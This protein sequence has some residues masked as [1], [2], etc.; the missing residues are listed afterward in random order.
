M[1]DFS[2]IAEFFSGTIPPRVMRFARAVGKGIN[3]LSMIEEGD[4]ILLGIS[5]GK[6]SLAMALALALRRK[7]VPVHYHLEAVMIQWREHQFS[8][9]ERDALAK[10][11]SALGVP[12]SIITA[13]MR[14]D[15][16]RGKFNCY[17][18]S[19]NRKRILFDEIARRGFNKVAFGHHLDDIVETTLMNVCFRGNFSTMMPVQEF[20]GGKAHVVRPMS[21]VPERT[22]ANLAD[23]LGLPVVS[24]DCEYK[25]KNVRVLLKPM[26]RELAKYNKHVKENIYRAAWNV[27][28]NYLPGGMGEQQATLATS[29]GRMADQQAQLATSPGRVEK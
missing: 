16:F 1:S 10:Y 6:D 29:P 3:E 28:H 14:P 23:H 19:R 18:C 20:F 17:L 5:G 8:D 12:F 27:D 11:F 22:I 7:W 21:R 15:S 25:E 13:S 4:R 26:I 9:T 24:V 2:H